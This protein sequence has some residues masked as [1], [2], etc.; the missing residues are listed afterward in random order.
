LY[1][2][3]QENPILCMSYCNSGGWQQ[4][5]NKHTQGQGISL[6]NTCNS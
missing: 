6:A 1:Y 5:G 2:H 3:L 4:S